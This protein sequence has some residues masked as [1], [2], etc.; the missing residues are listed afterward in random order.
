MCQ[1]IAIH[2][3]AYWHI[4]H[5]RTAFCFDLGLH[6]ILQQEFQGVL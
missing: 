2:S 3:A 6:N 5:F 4:D 1:Y